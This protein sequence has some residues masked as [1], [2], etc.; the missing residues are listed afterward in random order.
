ML[1]AAVAMSQRL[2]AGFKVIGADDLVALATAAVNE[3][4]GKAA[5]V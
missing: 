3:N 4:D 1:E 2:G 5:T